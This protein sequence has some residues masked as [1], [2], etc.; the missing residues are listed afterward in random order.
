MG[1]NIDTSSTFYFQIIN[2]A[3]WNEDKL[4]GIVIQ[5]REFQ[6]SHNLNYNLHEKRNRGAEREKAV[7][8]K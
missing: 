5:R 1:N 3:N 4:I 7:N 2:L 8:V 6:K